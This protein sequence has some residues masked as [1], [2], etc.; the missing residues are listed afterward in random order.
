MHFAFEE[1]LMRLFGY[2]EAEEHRRAHDY[3]FVRLEGIANSA[4]RNAAE[5]EMLEFLREWLTTH[6]LG[7]DQG[8]ARHILSGASIVRADVPC[9]TK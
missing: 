4:L 8:Y 9:C 1:A 5:T 6:I 2:P 7:S 3:F